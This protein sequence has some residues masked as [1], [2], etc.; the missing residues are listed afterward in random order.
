MPELAP[1]EVVVAVMA[2]SVNFNSVWSAIFE[3][4][5]TFAFLHRRAQEG[6]G[7]RGTTCRT[8]SSARTPP[9]W[10]SDRRGGT[11][12]VGRRPGGRLPRCHRPRRP[13]VTG[14]RHAGGRAARLGVRDQLRRHGRVHVVRANQL[15]PK[16]ARLTWEEAAANT[17]CAG[18]AYRMLVGGHGARMKQGDVVLIWGATGGLGGYAVQF[19]RNGGGIPVVRGRL[20]GEGRLVR[21]L[22]AEHVIDRS[23]LGLGEKGLRDPAAWRAIGARSGG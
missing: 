8:T 21:A 6:G 19:V 4:V 18:T 23:T 2:A 13:G 17:L 22:G 1:D 16:P 15:I 3:P 7:A 9:A 12:L 5:P 11:A 10:W 14:R 20:G